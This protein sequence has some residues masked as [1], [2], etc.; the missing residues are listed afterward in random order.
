M[1]KKVNY[2]DIR[3]RLNTG[4]SVSC[5]G[6]SFI[7]WV[8]RIVTFNWASH[9]GFIFL[10]KG[11]LWFADSTK[12]SG[13][14]GFDIQLLSTF[15]KNYPG[16]IRIR[17]LYGFDYYMPAVELDDITWVFINRFRGVPYEQS[18]VVLAGAAM[19]WKNIEDERSALSV[20]CSEAKALYYKWIGLFPENTNIC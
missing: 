15:I 17:N 1:R 7:S 11:S 20:F 5:Q 8:I 12:Q 10:F 2:N 16:H 3:D 6:R 18:D 13:R 19:P 14:D 9:D 4:A